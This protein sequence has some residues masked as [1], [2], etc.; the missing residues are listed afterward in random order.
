MSLSP[1]TRLGPYEILAP[2]GAGG[3]GEV[4]KARDTR[5]DRTVAIKVLPS[6]LS[7]DP[8][9]RTRFEREARA[10]SSLN[11]PNICTLHDIGHQD[12]IDFLVMEHLEGET[13]AA[14]LERG[15]LATAQLL[16][17]AVEITDAL[18]KAHRS[19]IVHR[20]LKPGNVMLTKS[21]TKLLDFGLARAA[22]PLAAAG[23]LTQSPT[24]TR[25]LTAEGTIVGTFQYMAPEQLEGKEADA[26]TDIFA[27]GAVL[28]EMATGKRAFEGRSQASLIAAILKEDPRPIS[29]LAPLA[30]P[31]LDRVVRHC[32][33]KDPD[34]RIQTA[35]DVRLELLWISEGSAEVGTPAQVAAGRRTRERLWIA[36][37][38][39]LGAALVALGL[40]TLR[41]A[42]KESPVVRLSLVRPANAAYESF[43]SA[44]VSPEGNRVAFV[45]DRKDGTSSLWVRP[46]D[47]LEAEPLAKTEGATM[48][49]WSPDSRFLGYFA[50]GRLRKIDA[51]GGPPQTVCDAPDPVGG[52]WGADDVILFANL[53]GPIFK[54]P[55]T[56]GSPT[57]VTRVDSS[58]VGH[59]WPC[60]LPDGRRFVFLGDAETTQGHHLK[61]GSL[62]SQESQDLRVAVTNVLCAPPDNLL[63]VLSGDVVAHRLD[64]KRARLIGDPVVVAEQVV[65]TGGWHRFEFSA[66][67][68]GV[69]TFRSAS[70]LSQLAWFERD[71]RRAESVGEPARII[72]MRLSPDG[73]RAAYVREDLD[74]RA[75]D[76]WM[77]DLARGS[78]SRF[79]LDPGSDANPIWSPD[80]SAIL[81]ASSRSGTYRLY[82]QSTRGSSSEEVVDVDT[83]QAYDWSP[84][85]RFL[86]VDGASDSIQ[87][88]L[89]I[90]L[91]ETRAPE[92][93][94]RD[95][96]GYFDVRFS[97]DGRW[98]AYGLDR[99]GHPEIYIRGFQDGSADV[100]VST[101]SGIMPRWSRLGRE[102]FYVSDRTLMAV[103][104][105]PGDPGEPPHVSAPKS[106]FTVP[107]G[108]IDFAVQNEG[109]RFLV[110]APV[111]DQ[112]SA[113]VTVVLNWTEELRKT[114]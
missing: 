84:D 107:G 9:R 108:V 36:V 114:R 92:P 13:L 12:G 25:P 68:N 53:W 96:A 34:D 67:G 64:E 82:R 93:L 50:E 49:F 22:A 1:G 23:D 112:W 58:E 40:A 62:D 90:S 78:N 38:L 87:T 35:H 65:Q 51:S 17:V 81:F 44:A 29:A 102:L 100:Q 20:D 88:I 16:R 21:G 30:P 8:D 7:A 109:D 66:S 77:I 41:R 27:F 113:P 63:Y 80:G 86:L 42:P 4:Y 69:L 2:L 5:L 71:G 110:V 98:V 43:H 31:A 83:G 19:G 106:L 72:A 11:H 48:P 32:L 61:I 54:V 24:M 85:G 95:A 45:G 59:L 103:T 94:V 73:S 28:Y 97:P 52:T 10:V 70:T 26:R 46:L 47:R 15:P 91:D 104:V 3:M 6:H 39:S 76:I 57:E 56:G 75:G 37:A 89:V 105:E 111:E 18:E 33:A 55:A 74:G 99:S 14:R 79:T 101:G 60:F